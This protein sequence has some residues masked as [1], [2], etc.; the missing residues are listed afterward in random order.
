MMEGLGMD[1]LYVRLISA[2]AESS[3]HEDD[4]IRIQ[5]GLFYGIIQL[6]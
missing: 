5:V 2:A 6:I 1:F 3:H 4:C